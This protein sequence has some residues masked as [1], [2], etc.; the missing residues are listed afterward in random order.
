LLLWNVDS[1]C[2]D[3][4]E[5]TLVRTYDEKARNL[6]QWQEFQSVV[7]FFMGKKKRRVRFSH[8]LFPRIFWFDSHVAFDCCPSSPENSKDDMLRCVE[9]LVCA[10]SDFGVTNGG[11]ISH[12]SALFENMAAVTV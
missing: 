6:L 5:E 10:I 3:S 12:S 8:S 2:S 11:A 9:R 4:A 7:V 1:G